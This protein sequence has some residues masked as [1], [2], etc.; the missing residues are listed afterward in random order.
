[1]N[2]SENDGMSMKLS[3]NETHTYMYIYMYILIG[4]F[5]HFL[6]PFHVWDVIPTPLANSIIFQD[7]Y[8]TTNQHEMHKMKVCVSG[9]EG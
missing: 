8:C 4:G 7:G 2:I 9:D 6:F 5:K 3:Y 1:M